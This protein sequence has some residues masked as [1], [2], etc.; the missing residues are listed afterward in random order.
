MCVQRCCCSSTPAAVAVTAMGAIRPSQRQIP[1]LLLVL[2]AKSRAGPLRSPMGPS[3]AAP[4]G[5]APWPC[6]L[7]SSPLPGTWST[8]ALPSGQL[9]ARVDTTTQCHQVSKF[10]IH[11]TPAP[12]G[13]ASSLLPSPPSLY[14]HFTT[15]EVR[16]SPS[17][18]CHK[19][20]RRG[21]CKLIAL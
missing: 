1:R 3:P 14:E 11:P 2:G 4:P 9:L 15:A 21:C 18:R 5:L 8:R 20:N 6:R 10:I 13:E 12:L 16:C 17:T 7:R 19:Q